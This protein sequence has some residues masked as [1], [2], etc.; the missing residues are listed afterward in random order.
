MSGCEY[1]YPLTVEARRELFGMWMEANGD[2][3]DEIERLAVRL[4]S[5]GRHVPVQYLIER[6]RM[7]GTAIL[8]P[9]AYRDGTGKLRRYG[10][11]HNDRALLGR[12][13]KGRHPG[14][15]VTMRR[16]MFDEPLG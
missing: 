8:H 15:R 12:W 2:A 10:I 16:S 13:L 9:I 1:D 6:Q 4:D 11:N 7:E 3:V 5:A 14:M